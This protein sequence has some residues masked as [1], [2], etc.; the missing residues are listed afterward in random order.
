[1]SRAYSM[2]V[3]ITDAAADRIADVKEAAENVWPFCNWHLHEG[4]LTAAADGNLCGGEAE[5]EFSRLLGREI[6]AA[7]GKFCSIEVAAT[8][9]ENLPYETYSLDE[10]DYH[11]LAKGG[12]A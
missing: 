12:P 9:L 8:C 11:R 2:F 4:M 5:D 3:R 1:M 6:W 10:D 7:N